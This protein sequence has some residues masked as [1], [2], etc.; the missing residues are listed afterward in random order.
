MQGCRTR[1]LELF[2]VRCIQAGRILELQRLYFRLR[3]TPGIV[4]PTS[5]MPNYNSGENFMSNYSKHFI[6]WAMN[7]RNWRFSY[8]LCS[9]ATIRKLRADDPWLYVKKFTIGNRI[10]TL[11]HLYSH[12]ATS[13]GASIWNWVTLTGHTWDIIPGFNY[14][15]GNS[16]CIRKSTIPE[17]HM[18]DT[19]WSTE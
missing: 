12:V 2:L 4:T 8:L 11:L 1:K 19:W 7:G 15:G 3:V 13:L 18:H 5:K 14:C 16:S 10:P 17:L 9:T 6:F